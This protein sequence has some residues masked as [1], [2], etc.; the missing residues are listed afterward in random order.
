MG[1]SFRLSSSALALVVAAVVLSGCFNSEP[2]TKAT[3]CEKFD[4]LGKE[5]LTTHILSDNVVFRRAGDLADAAGRYEASPTVKAEAERIQKIADS[6]S[7]SGEQLLNAT[8]AV[9]DVCGHPLGIGGDSW[10]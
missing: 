3:L 2:T 5:L 8:Q 7:T 4:A 9:A 1:K 10:P 6:D